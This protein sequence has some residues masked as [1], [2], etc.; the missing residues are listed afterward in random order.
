MSAIIMILLQQH[1]LLSGDVE[2]N[3]GPARIGELINYIVT[4]QDLYGRGVACIMVTNEGSA[5]G[6][7][8]VRDFNSKGDLNFLISTD[9]SGFS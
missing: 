2:L 5:T 3:P 7:F 4:T 6:R 1:L 8:G 9:I